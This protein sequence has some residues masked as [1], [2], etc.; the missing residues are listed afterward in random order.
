MLGHIEIFWTNCSQE[1]NNDRFQ[2]HVEVMMV[3][4]VVMVVMEVDLIGNNFAREKGVLVGMGSF[5]AIVKDEPLI[6]ELLDKL[7]HPKFH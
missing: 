2:K 3:V 6:P 5:C 4:M 1:S 7:N